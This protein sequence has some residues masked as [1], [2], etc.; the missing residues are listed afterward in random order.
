MSLEKKMNKV[1]IIVGPTA[2]GKTR[3]AIRLAKRINGE[4]VSA[5]SRY[6]YR[7]MD[8][9][10]A[11][12]SI[13]EREGVPHH[14]IDIA[15]PDETWSLAQYFEVSRQK[16]DEIL[17]RRHVPIIVGGT[18][19]YIRAMTEGWT[20]PALEPDPALRKVLDDWAREIGPLELFRKLEVVDREACTFIDASNVRRTIR[21]LEVIFSTG[22]K[23]STLR[24]KNKPE[25]EFW[26]VGLTLPRSKLYANVDQRIEEMFNIGLVEEVKNLLL[27][28]CDDT[29]PSMSAIG[30]REVAQYLKGKISIDEVKILMRRNT[31]K[32]IRRQANWFKP[33]DP[34]IHW[35][36]VE[37]DPLDEIVRDIHEKFLINP[38][39]K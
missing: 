25:N 4:I 37:E 31:R 35:Y 26:I 15:A 9:G 33:D 29:L 8:I 28:G 17:A 13:A 39:T 20:V 38:D 3:L 11:K 36:S 19:Q 30:Y 34:S 18:G 5:D 6:I 16:I 2:V 22:K 1:V 7:G 21:A 14:M 27:K 24:T 12:P 32:F 10:S 23:F